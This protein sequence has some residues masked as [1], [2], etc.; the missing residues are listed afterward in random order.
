LGS[1]ARAAWAQS[2]EL[3]VDFGGHDLG[4]LALAEIKVTLEHARVVVE[5]TRFV[6]CLD[7]SEKERGGLLERDRLRPVLG[8]ARCCEER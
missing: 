3:A 7:R 1:R 6:L 2:V 4:D 8:Q 5:R